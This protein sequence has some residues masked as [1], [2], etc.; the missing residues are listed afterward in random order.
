MQLAL[1]VIDNVPKVDP[2]KK[3][4]VIPR[5]SIKGQIEF[6]NVCFTYPTR[7]EV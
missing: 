2:E 3:G 6:K 4:V 7:Q 1:N 5:E